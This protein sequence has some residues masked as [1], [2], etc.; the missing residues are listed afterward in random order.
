MLCFR[1]FVLA[2]RPLLLTVSALAKHLEL[3]RHPLDGSSEVGQLP[4][5][6]RYVLLGCHVVGFYAPVECSAR[7]RATVLKKDGKCVTL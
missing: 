2:V 5:N 3:L 6:G 1:S 4:S 7:V